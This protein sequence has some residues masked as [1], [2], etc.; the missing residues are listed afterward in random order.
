MH[1][2]AEWLCYNN[3]DMAVCVLE[4]TNPADEAL[5]QGRDRSRGAGLVTI[6][7]IG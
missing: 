1:A 4:C 3:C 2:I 6:Y 5:Q 7:R